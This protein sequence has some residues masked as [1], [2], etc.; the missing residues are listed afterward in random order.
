M[1]LWEAVPVVNVP[2]G[3]FVIPLHDVSPEAVFSADM[4]RT[5]WAFTRGGDHEPVWPV[6]GRHRVLRA[7]S[8]GRDSIPTRLLV[9]P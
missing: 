1:I 4:E 2:V 9:I 5:V 3:R 7:W 8:L 6:D